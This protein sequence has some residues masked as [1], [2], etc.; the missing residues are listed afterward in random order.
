M[1]LND[2]MDMLYTRFPD[3]VGTPKVEQRG[4]LRFFFFTAEGG[5]SKQISHR[6]Y[7]VYA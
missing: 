3:V 7:A 1:F 6:M 5:S 4:A 2:L